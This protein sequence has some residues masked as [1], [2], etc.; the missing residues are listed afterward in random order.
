M[1]EAILDLFEASQDNIT[2]TW[3][4]SGFVILKIHISIRILKTLGVLLPQ[5]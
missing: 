5:I 2:V 1:F 3:K 4:L